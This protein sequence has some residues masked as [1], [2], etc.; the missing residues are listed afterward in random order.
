MMQNRSTHLQSVERERTLKGNVMPPTVEESECVLAVA[1]T[2]LCLLFAKYR[3]LKSKKKAEK[4][5]ITNKQ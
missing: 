1:L 4:L 3:K 2:K 5:Q